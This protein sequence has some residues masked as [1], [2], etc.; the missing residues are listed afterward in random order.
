MWKEKGKGRKKEV[1]LGSVS[2]PRNSSARVRAKFGKL[3]HCTLP[4]PILV[5]TIAAKVT[6]A[7]TLSM[8][9]SSPNNVRHFCDPDT[10]IPPHDRC[11][12]WLLGKIYS[13]AFV[14]S[15]VLLHFTGG[16]FCGLLGW[17]LTV[18]SRSHSHL[19]TQSCIRTH[20]NRSI[21]SSI[22][23]AVKHFPRKKK[24]K[25]EADSFCRWCLGVSMYVV[26]FVFGC[27]AF[28]R[29]DCRL[30]RWRETADKDFCFI[31]HMERI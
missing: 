14:D 25:G 13:S 16:A 12:W 22:I 10:H 11:D 21:V 17:T 30:Y 28:P 9:S 24:L 26:V 18:S 29:S 19:R 8:L 2:F 4:V 1:V 5:P 23:L 20:P 3:N 31:T 27:R 15:R 7:C 6:Q